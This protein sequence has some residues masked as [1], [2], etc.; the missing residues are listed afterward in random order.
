[1]SE[2]IKL[3]T[4]GTDIDHAPAGQWLSLSEAA[5]ATG[6]SVI[7]LR[8]YIK[9]KRVKCRR[10]GKTANAKLQILVTP[11]LTDQPE[12]RLTTEGLEDVLTA[13]EAEPVDDDEIYSAHG[14]PDQ[15]E[16]SSE[17]TLS[18]YR[19]QLDESR[20]EI[21]RLNQQLNG[22]HYRNGY[23]AAQVDVYKDQVKLL[24]QT[25]QEQ[26]KLLTQRDEAPLPV[27]SVS[28]AVTSI[29]TQAIPASTD[30]V[31]RF[32]RWFTGV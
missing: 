10:L 15:S 3:S 20:H 26:I 28:D 32:K 21:E 14:S 22:A 31:Q 18:W 11:E 29:E 1:M 2:Q 24:A 19:Q 30:W 25:N 8:R 23:L 4:Q 16:H 12:D 9:T 7:T 17:E 13:T 5:T 27:P 6:L